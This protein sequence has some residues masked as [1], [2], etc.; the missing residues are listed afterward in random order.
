MNYLLDTNAV[1]AMIEGRGLVEA[2]MRRH[3]ID[4][5]GLP[6][7]VA[8]ELYAGAFRSSR[9]EDALQRVDAL[10]FTVV[11]FDR[12]DA[13]IAGRI[14]AHLSRTCTPIGPVDVLIAAQGLA[15]D[16]TLVTHNTREFQRVPGLRVVDWQ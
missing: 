11:D 8:Y 7:M 5:F 9:P 13:R 4:E 3:R 15:R 12:G 1:I 10:A 14:R 16:L 6:A 2:E